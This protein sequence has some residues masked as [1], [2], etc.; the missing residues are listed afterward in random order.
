M[1]EC[2]T[3]GAI[4][5]D[6]TERCPIIGDWLLGE[7]I[8]VHQDVTILVYQADAGKGAVIAGGSDPHHLAVDAD[9]PSQADDC[10]DGV[11]WDSNHGRMGRK[12]GFQ[13]TTGK[14][15]SGFYQFRSKV[16]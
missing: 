10:D 8:L 4:T 9:E 3:S 12:E 5:P 11:R 15:S 7:S 13:Y 2:C 16:R 6:A 14:M 1:Y